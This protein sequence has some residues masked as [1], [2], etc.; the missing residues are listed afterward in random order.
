MHWGISKLMW[1]TV[2][3]ESQLFYRIKSTY[4]QT[5][6]FHLINHGMHTGTLHPRQR[7][8][9]WNVNFNGLV[10]QNKATLYPMISARQMMNLT[11]LLG[12]LYRFSFGI[13]FITGLRANIRAF[14]D[15]HRRLRE[16]HGNRSLLELMTEQE[17]LVEVVIEQQ[18]GVAGYV[19]YQYSGCK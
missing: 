14:G 16:E 10:S 12:Q 3:F 2:E 1:R 15:P 19:I 17:F 6:M 5:R 13:S 7:P 11:M 4:I 9:S 18:R 8:N